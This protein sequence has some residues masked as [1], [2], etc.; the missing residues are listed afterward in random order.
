[1]HR[2]LAIVMVILCAIAVATAAGPAHAGKKQRRHNNM[3][4]GWRWPPTAA[5]KR[6]GRACLARLD[7]L[8][9]RWRK[10]AKARK[11]ATPIEVPSMELGGIKLVSVYRKPPFVM[12][13]QLAVVLAEHGPTLYEAGVREI[14]W[15]SIHRYT[16]VR[17]GGKQLRALSRHALG[18]AI[19]IRHIVDDA[20]VAH[21]VETD[22]L[23][24]DE[25]LLSVETLINESGGFRLALT[26]ANDPASH[27][28]HFHFE[29][30]VDYTQVP[31]Q[32]RSGPDRPQRAKKQARRESR[33]ARK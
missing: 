26:P 2:P 31:V 33:T 32:A 23:N 5:M 11:I 15:S 20:G 25:L 18:L 1:M 24:G 17:T 12:D 27:D 21:S 8:G 14:H 30:K 6:S 22:Y 16:R 28:D 10:G 7:Q 9:V 13:C 3:P 29:A 4:D 19:D